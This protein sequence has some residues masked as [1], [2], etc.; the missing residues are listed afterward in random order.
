MRWR[1]GRPV[2]D[3]RL[4]HFGQQNCARRIAFRSERGDALMSEHAGVPAGWYSDPTDR[5]V[6]RYWDGQAWTEHTHH[7]PANSAA[8]SQGN[9]AN[10]RGLRWW[11]TWWA[12]VPGL[13]LCLPFRLIALWRRP[14]T[15]RGVKWVVTGVTAL[16]LVVGFA[17]PDDPATKPATQHR[18]AAAAPSASGPVSSTPTTSPS[19]TPA[20]VP[21][22]A[23][24]DRGR[25]QAALRHL[26]LK[27]GVVQ[28]QP[29]ALP[30]GS[31]LHQ[32]IKP[33]TSLARG[34]TVDLTIAAP[35]PKVPN[36]VGAAKASAITALQ[37]AG[38]QV[39][40]STKTTS[41]GADNTVLSETPSGG[42]RAKPG[43]TITL[44]I[45]DLHKPQTLSSAGS[46]SCTPGYSPCLPPASDYDCEGGSGDGPKYTGLVHVT[47]SDP[48]DLDRDGDG[49]GCD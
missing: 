27:V 43:A 42:N 46:S 33:G 31:V 39:L 17:L 1:S 2:L 10:S 49:V 48:Y 13:L 11:L 34:A 7:G 24:L 12:I 20:V 38:F 36:V 47:G 35:L 30:P 18:Q 23:G 40:I 41:S 15:A 16:L 21:R 22:L 44:V 32:A 19:P 8:Q 45:S 28:T 29:S 3:L 26:G 4:P 6:L 9:A 37:S 5:S 25:A 14:N